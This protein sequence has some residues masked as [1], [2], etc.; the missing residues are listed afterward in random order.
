M[1]VADKTIPVIRPDGTQTTLEANLKQLAKQ[2]GLPYKELM[3]R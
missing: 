3:L 1:I 2:M